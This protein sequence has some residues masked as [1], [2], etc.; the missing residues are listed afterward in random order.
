MSPTK[1][2]VPTTVAYPPKSQLTLEN[3][4]AWIEKFG[5]LK[6]IEVLSEE[7]RGEQFELELVFGG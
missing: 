5:P 1:R 4:Q 2:R 6:R 3:L 7:D